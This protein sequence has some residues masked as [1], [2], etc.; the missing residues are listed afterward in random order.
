M[1][2][3]PTDQN[4]YDCKSGVLTTMLGTMLLFTASYDKYILSRPIPQKV[5]HSVQ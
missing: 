2:V 4:A 3:E 1:G 5:Q